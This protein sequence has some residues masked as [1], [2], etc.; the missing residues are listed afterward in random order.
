MEELNDKLNA[1]ARTDGIAYTDTGIGIAHCFKWLVPKVYY[2]QLNNWNK[3]RKPIAFVWPDKDDG[4]TYSGTADTLALA[5][6]LAVEKLIDKE[7][8]NEKD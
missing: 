1:W 3:K 2:Y 7:L 6:S 4:K 8:L 5:F